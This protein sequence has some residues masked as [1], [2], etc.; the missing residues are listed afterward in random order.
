MPKPGEPTTKDFKGK[1]YHLGCK[2]HPNRW[3]CHTTEDC[4][5][6]PVNSAAS[7][8]SSTPTTENEDKK[9]GSRRLR[10]A[11]LAAALLEE[12]EETEEDDDSVTS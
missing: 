6:N 1:H 5:L 3:V 9:T 8:S 10:K 2:Y 12:D 7:A 11:K 4:S